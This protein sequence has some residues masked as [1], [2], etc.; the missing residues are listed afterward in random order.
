MQLSKNKNHFCLPVGPMWRGQKA[1]LPGGTAPR[2]WG[3]L[4]SVTCVNKQWW[5]VK[6]NRAKPEE[7][8]RSLPGRL[9]MQTEHKRLGS[10]LP[11]AQGSIGSWAEAAPNRLLL[12]SHACWL[13]GSCLFCH[14]FGVFPGSTSVTS[15]LPTSSWLSIYFLE[16]KW[17]QSYVMWCVCVH[18]CTIH[19]YI[20]YTGCNLIITLNV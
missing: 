17:R 4:Y 1:G 12:K 3:F 7:P 18:V 2:A 14:I 19:I 11:G 5:E 16:N 9:W 15:N 8:G 6:G 10:A 13:P 20:L